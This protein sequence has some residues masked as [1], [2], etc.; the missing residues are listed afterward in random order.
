MTTGAHRR[1]E[2]FNA[3]H[4]RRELPYY[5]ILGVPF[6][7]CTADIIGAYRKLS[8]KLHPDKPGGSNERFQELNRAYKCL[9]NE[10]SRRKYDDCGFDEDNIDTDEVDEF[11]DAF[12][13]ESAR[14]F[15]G[16]SGDWSMGSIDNYVPIDLEE[17][18]FHMKDIVRIGLNYIVALDHD[19]E[20]LVLLQHSRVDILYLMVGIFVPGKL[21]QSIFESED[22]YSITY[23]D[24]P[25]QPGI[26]PVW[27]DQNNLGTIRR[28]TPNELPRKELNFEEFQRRQKIALA[29]IENGPPDPLAALE[30]KYRT[31]MLAAQHQSKFLTHS[32]N[33]AAICSQDMYEEDCELDC[34]S[35]AASLVKPLDTCAS[36]SEPQ[37]S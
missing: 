21:T 11:V 19:F 33:S 37:A 14:R 30:E 26:K 5:A 15:D 6:D 9:K 18:P 32:E 8:L 23:Y 36:K 16:R 13:G 34:T 12:F 17:V 24:N 22:S 28:K 3:A 20:N 27:S 1:L 7:A 31:K 35:F 4:A 25:L 29:M 10:T 2:A